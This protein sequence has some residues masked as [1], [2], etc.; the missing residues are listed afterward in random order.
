MVNAVALLV[1]TS[2]FVV[3]DVP[4]FKGKK[5]RRDL[6]VWIAVWIVSVCSAGIALFKINVPSPLILMKN[7]YEPI[8]KFITSLF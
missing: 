1:L 6:I 3:V 5:M 8:N 4:F 2:I 7:F